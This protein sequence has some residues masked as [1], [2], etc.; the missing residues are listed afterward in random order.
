M[1]RTVVDGVSM[2]SVWQPRHNVYFNSYLIASPQGNLV[3]DPLALDE[4]DAAQIEAQGGIAWIVIT[5]RDHERDARALAERFGVQ[6][7]AATGDAAA[8]SV[9]VARTLSEGDTLLGAR[10]LE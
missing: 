6:I 9:A 4:A 7:A 3:T 2:W 5:N 8:L 1:Q 10:V